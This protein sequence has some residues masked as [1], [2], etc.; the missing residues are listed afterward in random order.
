MIEIF[1]KSAQLFILTLNLICELVIIFAIKKGIIVYRWLS[2]QKYTTSSSQKYTT[3]SSQKYTT[4]LS[5]KY[6]IISSSYCAI[7]LSGDN[8]NGDDGEIVSWHLYG[9][10][11]KC[12]HVTYCK[13][14]CD[15]MK[16]K[17]VPSRCPFCRCIGP[18]ILADGTTLVSH[19]NKTIPTN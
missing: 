1:A 14:C 15:R 19:A 10:Y 7:C 4:S 8:D 6:Y 12:G 3:S 5:Q 18:C 16:G 17:N 13:K 2:S 11:Q 9:R